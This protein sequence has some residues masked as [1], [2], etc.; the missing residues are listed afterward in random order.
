MRRLGD[1]LKQVTGGGKDDDIEYMIVTPQ[2]KDFESQIQYRKKGSKEWNSFI[3]RNRNEAQLTNLEP[4]T[5]YEIR[6]R[7]RFIEDDGTSGPWE[8]WEELDPLKTQPT[9]KLL[10]A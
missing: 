5:E 4:D 2:K 7:N 3:I 8:S 9:K 6:V 10:D 1:K